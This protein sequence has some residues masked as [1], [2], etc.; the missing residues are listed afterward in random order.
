MFKP[1]EKNEREDHSTALGLENTFCRIF[2]NC[3]K[4]T[5]PVLELLLQF[6]FFFNLPVSSSLCTA[7]M[8][9]FLS[10]STLY[11]TQLEQVLIKILASSEVLITSSRWKSVSA[12][13][14]VR[15]L[16]CL[17]STQCSRPGVWS[18]LLI[19]RQVDLEGQCM[20]GRALKGGGWSET[21]IPAQPS[22]R[23]LQCT[24]VGRKGKTEEASVSQQ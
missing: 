10:C 19:L 7:E 2:K 20:R 11:S 4:V 15:W 21:S 6:C 17:E 24:H 1:V 8:C 22:A 16:C 14:A 3:F 9:C 13:L 12:T 5:Q 23:A 18:F